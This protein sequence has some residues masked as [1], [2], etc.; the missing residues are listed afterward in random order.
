MVLGVSTSETPRLH[1]APL[2]LIA[3]ELDVCVS[4]MLLSFFFCSHPRVMGK[5]TDPCGGPVLV[6]RNNP[7]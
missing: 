5:K 4:V 2:F 1:D 3:I 7:L 6:P